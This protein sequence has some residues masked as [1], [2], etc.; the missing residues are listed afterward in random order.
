MGIKQRDYFKDQSKNRY[1]LYNLSYC[2]LWGGGFLF[3][4]LFVLFLVR[5]YFYFFVWVFCVVFCGF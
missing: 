2:F 4:L 1:L 5:Y 3:C